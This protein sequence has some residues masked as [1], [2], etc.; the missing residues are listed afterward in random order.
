MNTDILYKKYKSKNLDQIR[1][2]LKTIKIVDKVNNKYCPICDE[3]MEK[4]LQKPRNISF[5]FDSQFNEDIEL[6]F[7]VFKTIPFLVKSSSRFFLKPDIGEVFDQI[8][9]SDINRI[10]AIYVDSEN[11]QVINS[12]GDHFLM[13]VVLLTNIK[14]NRKEK[15]NKINDIYRN[16]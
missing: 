11:N 6:E 9:E 5:T 16:N 2:Y 8:D 15:L 4:I 10:S 13:E 1:N 7:T 3:K 14:T 12:E